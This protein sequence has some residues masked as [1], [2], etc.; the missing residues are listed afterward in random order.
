MHP[1]LK[2]SPERVQNVDEGLMVVPV[3]AVNMTPMMSSPSPVFALETVMVPREL[4]VPGLL[5]HDA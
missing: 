4:I 2:L 3:G 1:E 5:G